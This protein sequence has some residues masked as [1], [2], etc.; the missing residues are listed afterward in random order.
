MQGEFMTDNPTLAEMAGRL[1]VM[2]KILVKQTGLNAVTYARLSR[3][4]TRRSRWRALSLFSLGLF[5]GH[6]I[7]WWLV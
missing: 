7:A 2:E 4:E 3:L 6:T 1:G 5:I